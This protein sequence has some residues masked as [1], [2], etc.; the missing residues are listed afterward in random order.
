MAVV[1]LYEVLVK[2]AGFTVAGVAVGAALY[3]NEFDESF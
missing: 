3:L 1:G 2:R